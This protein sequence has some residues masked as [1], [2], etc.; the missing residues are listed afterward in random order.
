MRKWSKKVISFI[1]LGQHREGDVLI[2]SFLQPFTGGQGQI[3]SQWPEQRH[4]NIQA[5]GQGSLWQVIMYDY[6]N[7]SNREQRLKSKKQIQHGVRFSSSLLQS[8]TRS[9]WMCFHK[10]VRLTTME[11]SSTR[12]RRG[13]RTD[14]PTF[15]VFALSLCFT[16][17]YCNY[18]GKSA[19]KL[20]PGAKSNVGSSFICLCIPQKELFSF[21]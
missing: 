3:V 4:F 10:T 1:W 6:N 19:V 9:W 2:S 18:S 8:C 14:P 12:I 11:T 15:K 16:T 21:Q 5:E 7:K 20:D 17:S 13:E